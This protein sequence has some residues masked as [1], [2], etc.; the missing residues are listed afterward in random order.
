MSQMRHS[1]YPFVGPEFRAFTNMSTCA[2]MCA[3]ICNTFCLSV[4]TNSKPGFRS[5]HM[6]AACFVAFVS[7]PLSAPCTLGCMA[8]SMVWGEMLRKWAAGVSINVNA[9]ATTANP[10]KVV[11][12]FRFNDMLLRMHSGGHK[13]PTS[14]HQN[15]ATVL[16]CQRS[17][18]SRR[19]V[20]GE[21]KTAAV[22]GLQTGII[23]RRGHPQ[24]TS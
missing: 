23:L 7:N 18:V 17:P 4:S 13:D 5:D 12:H 2:G 19:P 24:E 15:T 22:E 20:S 6:T 8:Y 3:L 14:W 21:K 16:H 11:K 1:A 10:I 9:T